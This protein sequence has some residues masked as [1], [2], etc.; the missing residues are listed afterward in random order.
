MPHLRGLTVHVTDEGGND[1]KEWG[2]QSLRGNKISAYVESIPNMPFRISISPHSLLYEEQHA[3]EDGHESPLS[4][5]IDDVC[6]KTEDLS[7]IS[8]RN[9]SSTRHGSNDYSI[10]KHPTLR[11]RKRN[12]NVATPLVR[13]C[14][15]PSTVNVPPYDFMASLYL[16]GRKKAE[17]R[18]VVYLDPHHEDFAGPDG[19]VYF[20][21]RF[22]EGRDGLLREQGWVFQAVGI[23]A[24]FKKIA[25]HDSTKTKVE[26]DDFIVEAMSKSGFEDKLDEMIEE[27]GRVGQILVEMERVTLGRRYSERHYRPKHVEGDDDDLDM[28]GLDHQVAHV[29][30]FDLRRLPEKKSVPCIEFYPYRSGEGTWATFQFFYRSREQLQKFNFPGYPS[31]Q[32]VQKKAPRD[33]R[34]LDTALANITPLSI[35]RTKRH[36]SDPTKKREPTFEEQLKKGFPQSK[37]SEP[38]YKFEDFRDDRVQA[39]KKTEKLTGKNKPP[40]SAGQNRPSNPL[41]H[42]KASYT[43]LAVAEQEVFV[44]TQTQFSS[45]SS[46]SSGFE[47]PSSFSPSDPIPPIPSKIQ[48]YQPNAESSPHPPSGPEDTTESLSMRT[49]TADTSFPEATTRPQ[50]SHGEFCYQF[51]NDA[52]DERPYGIGHLSPSSSVSSLSSLH[53][54]AD[55]DTSDKENIPTADNEDKAFNT[56]MREISLG[57]K[58]LR[59]EGVEEL[60]NGEIKEEAGEEMP[61]FRYKVTA[62]SSEEHQSPEGKGDDRTKDE[63]KVKRIRA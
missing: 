36:A 57:T 10:K 19:I 40:G 17:K 41:S 6:I 52:D 14:E 42:R 48:I 54:S 61:V 18:I 8:Q 49:T 20:K 28:E 39:S 21:H 43:V 31:H 50:K 62:P 22:V 23:E 11:L 45:S 26:P 37:R 32:K 1:L 3:I 27:R 4:D 30:G 58:R 12:E 55:E 47:S 60:E 13:L 56:K 15:R 5:E 35:T 53:S 9:P 7:E 46:L 63:E 44:S 25:L 24:V 29:T 34:F 2:V 59:G 38:E 16:D 51:D 33:R